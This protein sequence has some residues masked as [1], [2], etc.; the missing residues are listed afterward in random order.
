MSPSDIRWHLYALQLERLEAEST[1]LTGNR[2]YMADLESER[3]EYERALV[4][5]RIGEVLELRSASGR[6][7]FG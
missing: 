7:Q 2:H 5:A 3:A 1:G 4:N 6:R